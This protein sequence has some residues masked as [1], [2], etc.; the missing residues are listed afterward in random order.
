M[1]IPRHLHPVPTDPDRTDVPVWPEVEDD[2]IHPTIDDAPRL[3]IDRHHHD[4]HHDARGEWETVPVTAV[5]VD[6]GLSGP[7]IEFGP[8]S[9][10]ATDARALAHSLNTLADTLDPPT[11]RT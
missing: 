2:P 4:L 10:D 9:L 8:W 7:R 6:D 11:R 3:L 1:S 5:Y